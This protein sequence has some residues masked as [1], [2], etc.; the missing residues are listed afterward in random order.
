MKKARI[1]ILIKFKLPIVITKQSSGK[2]Y[3]QQKNN[4]TLISSH[5]CEKRL[6]LIDDTIKLA[7]D[8]SYR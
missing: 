6:S 7:D 2:K 5:T 3:Q 4:Q 1:V 8:F